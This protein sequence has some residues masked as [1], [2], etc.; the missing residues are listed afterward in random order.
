MF[1]HIRGTSVRLIAY[2]TNPESNLSPSF[3]IPNQWSHNPS[4]DVTIQY[5]TIINSV[6]GVI[7]DVYHDGTQKSETG[8]HI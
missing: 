5:N 2:Q 4:Y 8:R 7:L 1:I 6:G 3:P